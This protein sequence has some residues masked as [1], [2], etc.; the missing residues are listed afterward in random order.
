MQR[1]ILLVSN[2][3]GLR[4]FLFAWTSGAICT[5]AFDPFLLTPV[6][7]ISFSNLYL[8]INSRSDLRGAFFD[9]WSFGFGF[10]LTGLYWISNALLIGG[11]QYSWLLPF[12]SI[13]LPAL[14]ALFVSF[15]MVF[16][17]LFWV[18]GPL[19]ALSFSCG[20]VVGEIVRG[21]IFGGFPWNLIGYSWTWSS[22]VLQSA[23]IIG[24][25]GISFITLILV[26]TPVIILQYGKSRK[27]YLW[28]FVSLIILGSLS[29]IMFGIERLQT[30][31]NDVVPNITLRLVQPNIQ[32]SKKWDPENIENNL[33]KLLALS[34]TSRTEQINYIIWPETAVTYFLEYEEEV[35]MRLKQIVPPGGYLFTGAPRMIL[36]DGNPSKL[37][38]TIHIINDSGNIIHSYDK[39]H[40]V[41][42]GEYLPFRNLLKTVSL[43]RIVQGGLDYSPGDG[44]R[45][46]SLPGIPI[47]SMLICYEAIFPSH[48]VDSEIR[49]AWLLN[50][51]NDAW[52]GDTVGPYQHFSIVRLRSIE[53]GLPLIRTANTGI[54]G[55]IDP[56]GRV[57]SSIN[58]NEAGF[59]DIQLPAAINPTIYS[60]YGINI[61][62]IFII[63]C[64]VLL[65][66]SKTQS[67][68]FN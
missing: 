17:K 34:T 31:S 33:N 16:A 18:S 35:L 20:W 57:V 46:F 27:Y 50:I 8:L 21:H 10:F 7:L 43:G 1:I 65:I 51:T 11:D 49:P 29:L 12:A 5:L 13:L 39:M 25:Y 30:S 3:Q 41:P 32:Q 24:I 62:I 40:L 59:L 38:N 53:Q 15:G 64:L 58:L 36:S 52:Y 26:T 48:V 47:V 23:S 61:P 2:L 22:I 28:T 67:R 37:W 4:R 6:L 44:P 42:F 63:T 14:L 54:T 68:K 60:K 66:F 9:G 19:G 55:L 56:F 45:T